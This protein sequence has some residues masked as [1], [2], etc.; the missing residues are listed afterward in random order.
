MHT[1]WRFTGITLAF[2][3]LYVLAGVP[4]GFWFGAGFGAIIA[5]ATG[6]KR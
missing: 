5:A 3:T 1:F 2:G 4:G 6:G